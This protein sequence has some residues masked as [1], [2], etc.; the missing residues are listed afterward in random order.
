MAASQQLMMSYKV[1]ASGFTLITSASQSISASGSITGVNAT[2]ADL[3][4]IV[5]SCFFTPAPSLPTDSQSNTYTQAV[6]SAG[7]GQCR[8]YYC[9]APSVSSSMTFTFAGSNIAAAVLVFS[10]C[11][12]SSALQ[13]TSSSIG[14]SNPGSATS[15]RNNSLFVDVLAHNDSGSAPTIDSSFTVVENQPS[16]GGVNFGVTAAWRTLATAGS[17]NPTWTAGS[18]EAAAQAVFNPP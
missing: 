7:G 14:S 15:T 3:I 17:L 16:V 2:G 10:G 6:N 12:T 5:I 1:A 9:A 4:V 13:A 18:I 8:I 11:D